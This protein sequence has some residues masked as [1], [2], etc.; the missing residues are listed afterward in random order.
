[1][2]LAEGAKNRP[3]SASDMPIRMPP[4]IAPGIDPSPPMITIM[5]ASSV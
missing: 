4:K 1:M 3:A 5:K 2:L